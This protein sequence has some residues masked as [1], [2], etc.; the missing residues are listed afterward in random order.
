MLTTLKRKIKNYISGEDKFI[1]HFDNEHQKR[2]MSQR[3]TIVKH[4]KIA[5]LRDKAIKI[6]KTDKDLFDF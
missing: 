3:E 4:A 6:E 5:R 1:H 2:S